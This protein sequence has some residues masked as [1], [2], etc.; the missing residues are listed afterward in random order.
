MPAVDLIVRNCRLIQRDRVVEADLVVDC[1]KIAAIARSLG[2]Y[3]ADRSI[4]AG[5]DLVIPGLI[6]AHFHSREP[7]SPDASYEQEDFTSGTRAAAAGGYTLILDMPVPGSPPTTT[8]EGFRVKKGEAERK[9]VVDYAFYGGAGF[10]NIPEIRRLAEVGVVAFKTFTRE[11]CN[12]EDGRWSG[13]ALGEG[14]SEAFYR[15]MVEAER[16]GR[17]LSI[18]CEDDRLVKRLTDRLKAEGD[19]GLTAYYRSRPNESE[20]LEVARSISMARMVGARINIA[21][22]ST[23]ESVSLVRRAKL[24]GL[25][26]YAETAPHYLLLTDRDM[27]ESLGPYGK[28]YPP[29]RSEGDRLALWRALGDGTI[30]FIANDHAPHPREA[31]EPGWRDIFEAAAGI[32]GVETALPLMLTQVNRGLLSIFRLVELMS[33]RP[34]KVF[35]I[36]RKGELKVG[37]DGDFVIV[38]MDREGVICEEDMYTKG[39]AKVFEGWR[40]K[41]MPTLTAVRGEVVMEDGEVVGRPG[42]GEYIRPDAT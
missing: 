22:M 26:V 40:V 11:L 21:H 18:H 35:R 42:Y 24:E 17:L 27:V 32:P 13:V 36:G 25:P 34:A 6:D 8:L 2:G 41:G 38:D 33:R 15:V 29:L 10:G 7:H 31:K 39:S 19:M 1:G 28:A 37:L 12:P 5:G 20:F 14:G 3:T 16:A 30:D 4:D 23:A 9:C